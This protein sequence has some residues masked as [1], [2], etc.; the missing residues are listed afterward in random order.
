[1]KQ[2]N[3]LQENDTHATIEFFKFVPGGNPTIIVL[4]SPL[5]C[6]AL[7]QV[8]AKIMHPLHLHAEQVGRIDFCSP[9]PHLQMMGGEFCVNATRSA[10]ALLAREGLFF[11]PHATPLCVEGEISVSGAATPVR[12]AVSTSSKALKSHL[13]GEPTLL[14]TAPPTPALKSATVFSAARVPLE[15][16][17]IEYPEPGITL[18]HMPGISHLLLDVSS[19]PFPECWQKET[20][21]IRKRFGLDKEPACGIDWFS[22]R[23]DHC[24][25]WPVVYVKDT[26]SEV[27]ETACG[28]GSLALAVTMR[29]KQQQKK[30]EVVKILQPSGACLDIFFEGATAAWVSGPVQLVAYGNTLLT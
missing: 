24:A 6:S 14:S 20:P 7:P 15:G 29:A 13:Q 11:A 18:I 25:L 22:E 9:Y 2:D 12:C 30:T 5:T 26:A 3:A 8:A 28:S 19:Y 10:A 16:L 4:P 23:G 1:M 17:H 21:H 27:M